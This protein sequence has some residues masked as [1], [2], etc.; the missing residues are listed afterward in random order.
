[1]TALS[2]ASAIQFFIDQNLRQH[3]TNA[4]YVNI[5]WPSLGVI[6]ANRNYGAQYMI[7]QGLASVD[8]WEGEDGKPLPTVQLKQWSDVL[9]ITWQHLTTDEER[10]NVRWIARRIITNN[11]TKQN[12]G[13]ACKSRGGAVAAGVLRAGRRCHWW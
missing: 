11:L 12:I 13:K 3:H 5:F 9:F 8:P 4:E 1:M 7:E 10:A 2:T 6:F